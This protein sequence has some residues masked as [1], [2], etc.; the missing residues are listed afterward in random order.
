MSMVNTTLTNNQVRANI[1][2]GRMGLRFMLGAY[3]K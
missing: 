2:A 3:P 1:N